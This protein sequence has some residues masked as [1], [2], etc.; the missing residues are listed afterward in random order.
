M[1]TRNLAVTLGLLVTAA[2]SACG[3][4]DSSGGGSNSCPASTPIECRGG[5]SELLGCC[6]TTHPVCSADG[7]S[8][9]AS[10]GGAS[11]SGG[12]SS[13]GASGSSS[14]GFGGSVGGSS[15]GGASSGGAS[16]SGGTATG[17]TSSGG[18]SGS[19]GGATGGVSGTGGASCVDVGYEPNETSGTAV[20]VGPGI[21]ACDDTGKVVFAK[22]DGTTD[23][24]WYTYFGTET[25]CFVDPAV[26][27][28]VN[29]RVCMY[30]TCNGITVSCKGSS[31]PDNSG[32]G[33]GC[34]NSNGGSL[35]ATP[36][37]SGLDDSATVY[38]RVDQSSKNQC[39]D[40][41]ID[42]HF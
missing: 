41:S 30:F 13:G 37:C 24:D 20:D 34:C 4:D 40:Y 25:A 10:A 26:T 15:S 2:V 38:I 19:G 17:G 28:D 6:P 1:K 11:G 3:S 23:V 32:P 42:F 12:A 5:G 18:A 39:V 14:G 36:N 9:Q 31:T 16:G 33:P 8:C 27:L 29:A 22:L 21:T 7:L 35:V